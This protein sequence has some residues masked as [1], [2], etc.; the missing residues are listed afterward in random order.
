MKNYVICVDSDG[1]AMDTMTVKHEL[2]FGPL[3][4][5]YF[6]IK[7]TKKFLEHWDKVN[8]YSKTRGINRFKGLKMALENAIKNGENIVDTRAF[9]EFVDNSPVLSAA[10]LE[11]QYEKTPDKGIKKAIEWSK[12]VNDGI[13]EQLTGKDKPFDEVLPT[14]EKF[15]DKADIIVVSSAN[16]GA[17]NSEWERH[18]LLKYTCEVFGQEEGT[19]EFAISKVI[20]E[21]YKKENILMVGDAPG[22]EKAAFKNGVKFYPII[23]KKE[24]ES[25][26]KLR[27]IVFDDLLDGKFDQ[28]YQN[29]L[30]DEFHNSLQ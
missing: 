13:H 14:F 22:D 9:N 6:D 30:L 18:G 10:A 12:A 16:L 27:E 4:A 17:I 8:L 1:C 15:V 7:N 11:K 3:A 28:D 21:G 2:F 26:K 20:E 29:K 5:D 24:N 19:K 23:T 25:W